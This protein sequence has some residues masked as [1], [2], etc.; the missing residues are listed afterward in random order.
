MK[1]IPLTQGYFALVDDD[2]FKY[3][4][5]H[6]WYANALGKLFNHFY[7]Y[8]NIRQ[9][10]HIKGKPVYRGMPMA[11]MIMAVELAEQG[12]NM[13]VDHWNHNTLDNRR[14]NLRVC[15][16]SENLLNRAS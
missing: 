3:L 8:T 13:V 10:P 9:R 1:R 5:A 14:C 16:V 4:S 7:A 15:T 6:K 12:E 11:R 2:D